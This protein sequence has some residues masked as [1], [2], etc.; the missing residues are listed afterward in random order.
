VL[1][2]ED[3]AVTVIVK[4]IILFYNVAVIT[5]IIIVIQF[6]AS[7]PNIFLTSENKNIAFV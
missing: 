6:S 3:V 2:E 5:I 1:Q 4:H 7:A